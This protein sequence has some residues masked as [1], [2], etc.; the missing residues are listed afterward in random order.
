MNGRILNIVKA[1]S[2]VKINGKF[3]IFLASNIGLRQWGGGDLSPLLF[4]LF[5]NASKDFLATNLSGLKVPCE[6]AMAHNL[7]S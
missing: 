6:A 4:S 3:S 1:K 2:C 7:G 5:L